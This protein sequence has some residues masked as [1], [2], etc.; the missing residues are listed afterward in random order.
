MKSWCLIVVLLL[1]CALGCASLDSV[2]G[3]EDEKGV[4]LSEVPAPALQAAQGAVDGITLTEAEMDMEDGRTVYDIE[5][6]ADGKEYTIEVTAD[7]KVLEVE[8]EDEDGD[9]DDDDDDHE[10]DGHDDDDDH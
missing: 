8:Q 3:S 6:T 4:P 9:D 5:G 1:T 10:D 2:F 7:G